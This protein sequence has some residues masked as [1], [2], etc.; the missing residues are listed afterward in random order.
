MKGRERDM[1]GLDEGGSI[2]A[3]ATRLSRQTIYRIK[4]DSAGSEAAL[5]SWGR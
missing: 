3:K 1:L 2:I 4:N 5:L